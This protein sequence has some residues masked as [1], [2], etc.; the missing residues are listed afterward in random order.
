M[1]KKDRQQALLAAV[2][3]AGRVRVNELSTTLGVSEMT[4]RRDLEEMEISNLLLRVHG[5]AISTTSRSFEPGFHARSQLQVEAKRQIG[6]V[7]ASLIRDGETLI[8]DA[9]TTT[10]H[11]VEQLPPDIRIRVMALSLRVADVLAEMPNVTLM[12]PGGVVR[13]QER[14]LVGPTT[15]AALEQLTFDTV[16]L[17][18]GGVDPEA[19]ITEYEFDDA[20]TKRAALHSARRRILVA[21]STKLGAVSFVKICPLDMID[22]LV[23]DS[24]APELRVAELRSAGLEVLV[25]PA[26]RPGDTPSP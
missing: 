6:R 11:F 21:D 16:I 26:Q 24:N 20:A 2:Q 15:Q 10:L 19:G 18:T 9:G 14:S 22:I 3:G 7:T 5:G 17:T 4:V 1:N 13:H 12:V 25:A 23:T 8:V